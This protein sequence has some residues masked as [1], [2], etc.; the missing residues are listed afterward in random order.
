M[1]RAIN[2]A[3][4]KKILPL[5]LSPWYARREPAV[6]VV[7]LCALLEP[8]RIMGTNE[9]YI[10]RTILPVFCSGQCFF[11]PISVILKIQM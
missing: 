1:G 5:H 2:G 3:G 9:L 11:V 6:P 7:T 10:N 4:G 8:A